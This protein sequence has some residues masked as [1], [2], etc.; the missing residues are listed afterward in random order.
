MG[1]SV[2]LA[3]AAIGLLARLRLHTD[4]A[5][6]AARQLYVFGLAVHV[7]MV[8]LMT[9][10]PHEMIVDVMLRIGP[11]VLWLYPLAT[12]LAGKILSDPVLT[13]RLPNNHL[14]WDGIETDI[15]GRKQA[16]MEREKL[17]EHV[18]G[19]GFEPVT[20]SV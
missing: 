18:G 20:S 1:V 14:V 3:S 2:T 5:A 7:A 16:E 6:P 12:V 4:A 8:A 11:P 13:R 15:T 10:L 17:Q 9:T 19:T